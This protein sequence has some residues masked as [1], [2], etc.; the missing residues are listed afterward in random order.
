M[1]ADVLTVLVC[2]LF[3]VE[4]M[5]GFATMTPGGAGAGAGAGARPHSSIKKPR[6]VVETYPNAPV[7][8][9]SAFSS[10]A[11]NA[12]FKTAASDGAPP[13]HNQFR[14]KSSGPNRD[15]PNND[16]PQDVRFNQHNNNMKKRPVGSQSPDVSISAAVQQPGAPSQFGFAPPAPTAAVTA[17]VPLDGS[18]SNS[19]N[20]RK[21]HKQQPPH[22]QRQHGMQFEGAAL[23]PPAPPG[24]QYGNA[25]RVASTVADA[26]EDELAV[27]TNVKHSVLQE[28]HMTSDLFANLNI[29]PNTKKGL[30]LSLKYT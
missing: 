3:L 19:Q 5:S 13:R 26:N 15:F 18:N 17:A 4:R 27:P 11:G 28:G 6:T 12:G 21:K 16:N 10:T 20:R 1:S 29:H 22:Q 9:V 7:G 30:A 2:L 25:A 24:S 14:K 8:Q 23:M